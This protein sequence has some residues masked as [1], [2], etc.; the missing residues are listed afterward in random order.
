MISKQ[1][2]QL[3]NDNLDI[4]AFGLRN[5]NFGPAEFTVRNALLFPDMEVAAELDSEFGAS[6]VDIVDYLVNSTIDIDKVYEPVE[7]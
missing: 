7:L 4:L 3:I 1:S 2:K 6:F 5:K